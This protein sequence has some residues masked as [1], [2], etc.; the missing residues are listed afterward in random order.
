MIVDLF[1]NRHEGEFMRHI[2]DKVNILP[3]NSCYKSFAELIIS[4]VK[5]GHLAIAWCRLYEKTIAYLKSA[6]DSK[7]G[8]ITGDYSH[9]YTKYLIPKIRQNTEHDLAISFITPHYFVAEKVE[10]KYK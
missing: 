9:L 5:R 4:A 3:E 2:A 6:I 8:G 7:S 10:Q 1:L